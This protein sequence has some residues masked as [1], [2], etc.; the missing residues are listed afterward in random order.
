MQGRKYYLF[1]ESFISSIMNKKVSQRKKSHLC[2]AGDEECIREG[3]LQEVEFEEG[4]IY[5]D[6]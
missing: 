6:V 3:L 5:V 1:H 2:I 4:E